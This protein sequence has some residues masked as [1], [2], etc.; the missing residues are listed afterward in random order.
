MITKERKAQIVKEFGA[1]P[2]D[3]GKPEVQ[4]ALLT[5]H[6]EDLSKHCEINKKDHHSRRGLIMLVSKR[7]TLLSYLASRDI[8]RYRSIVATLGLRK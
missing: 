2:T 1:S 7:K 6:I 5:A 4:I 3:T 8:Q